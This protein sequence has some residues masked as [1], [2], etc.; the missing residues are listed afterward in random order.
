[1][2]AD[3]RTPAPLNAPAAALPLREA[4]ALAL[5]DMLAKAAALDAEAARLAIRDPVGE[6]CRRWQ[7]IGYRGAAAYLRGR[8]QEVQGE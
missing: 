2:P 6:V 4:V 1:M 8:V 3:T 5:E 7:A